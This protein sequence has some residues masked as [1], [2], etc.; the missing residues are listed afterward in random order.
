MA[1]KDD[2]TILGELLY[3][4]TAMGLFIVANCPKGWESGNELSGARFGDEVDGGAVTAGAAL[5]AEKAGR[6]NGGERWEAGG[7][8]RIIA[9]VE[10]DGCGVAGGV[11]CGVGLTTTTRGAASIGGVDG[12]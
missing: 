12:S 6:E 8:G 5:A 11:G 10:L 2:P 4:S 3:G 1:L 9:P 7:G